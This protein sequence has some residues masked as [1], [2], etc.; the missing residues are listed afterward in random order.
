M[1]PLVIAPQ[2]FYAP[3]RTRFCVYWQRS[4]WPDP[5][6]REES[7][8]RRQGEDFDLS[9]V[10]IIRIPALNWMADGLEKTAAG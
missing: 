4:A 8:D 3:R 5:W 9:G 1:K 7:A 10:R 6:A 2:P